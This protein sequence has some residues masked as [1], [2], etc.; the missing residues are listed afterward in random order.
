[1]EQISEA[2]SRRSAVEAPDAGRAAP[3]GTRRE[4]RSPRRDDPADDCGNPA[5][6]TGPAP[7]REGGTGPVPGVWRFAAVAEEAAVPRTRHEVRDRLLA[8]GMAGERYQEL[9]DDLLLIVSELVSNAVTHAAVVS[10]KLTTELTI[11]EGQVRIAVEDLHPYRPKALESDLGKLGGRG[12]LLVK[13]VTLQAGGVCD[14]ERTGDGGKVIWA[15]LP[16]PAG[17]DEPAG[18]PWEL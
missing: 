15:S 16:V 18:H 7:G 14:V 17:A 3:P 6:G 12:L 11:G 5:P 1:M 10:P 4:E 8:Q 2:A 13:S 9:I